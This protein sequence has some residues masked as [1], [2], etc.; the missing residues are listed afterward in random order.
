MELTA[1]YEL[2]GRIIG[3]RPINKNH[4]EELIAS[5]EQN[6]WLHQPITVNEKFEI[7]D[8]Q[9]RFEALR[10]LRLPI[11]Y[12]VVDSGSIKTCQVLNAN[13]R[14][15]T[16]ENYI[17]SFADNGNDNYAWIS[18]QIK[19]YRKLGSTVVINVCIGKRTYDGGANDRRIKDG[20]LV[21]D[22]HGRFKREDELFFMSQLTEVV[23]SL[24]GHSRIFWGA[25][26]YMYNFEGVDRTRLNEVMQ[27]NKYK[28][29][30]CGTVIED[31][32]QIEDLYNKGLPSKRRI[33]P[34]YKYKTEVRK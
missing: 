9:H 32:K 29:I 14:N 20:T 23:K 33:Y 16:V 19:L 11:E 17:D 7:I 6:G 15:W 1:N 10:A 30:T 22:K 24:K 21:I 2:F 12:T 34:S 28:L 27:Q 18:R 8:G 5:I 25:I 13:Q 3:N 4:V 26:D 31:I